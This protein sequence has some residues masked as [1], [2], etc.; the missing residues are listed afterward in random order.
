[1]RHGIFLVLGMGVAASLVLPTTARADFFS[2]GHKKSCFPYSCVDYGYT[3]T[4]WRPWPHVIEEGVVPLGEGLTSPTL[5]GIELIPAPTPLTNPSVP[6]VPRP[7]PGPLGPSSERR[8]N[9]ARPTATT[10]RGPENLLDRLGR[11]TRPGP[12]A[13][14][15]APRTPS[16]AELRPPA[17]TRVK[18]P[19]GQPGLLEQMADLFQTRDT[20]SPR[21]RATQPAPLQRTVQVVARPATLAPEA[22]PGQ[23]PRR[24]TVVRQVTPEM[25][26]RG[27]RESTWDAFVRFLLY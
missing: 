7:Q 13:P 10:S 2:W 5:P 9:S 18:A 24:E 19:T 8:H 26:S 4:T 12:V 16:A 11:N 3:P 15:S 1:M 23:M 22:S 14:H 20:S 27:P 21:I 25:S 6:E 17:Q